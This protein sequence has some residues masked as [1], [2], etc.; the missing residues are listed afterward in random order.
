M[1]IQDQ[2]NRITN[3]VGTQSDLIEQI[4]SALQGKAVGDKQEQT[5][6]VTINENGTHHI[7]PDEGYTLSGVELNVDVQDDPNS[8]ELFYYE[9]Y[10][11]EGY[12]HTLVITQSIPS[13]TIENGRTI[14]KLFATHYYG[15]L[16]I[17]ARV[18]KV[19]LP[20]D[21]T[22][23]DN[24]LMIGYAIDRVDG[25]NNLVYIG[26]DSFY[27]CKILKT[28][29]EFPPNLTWLGNSAF[30]R[31]AVHKDLPP[32]PDGITNIGDRCF[33]YSYSGANIAAFKKLPK[34]LVTIGTNAFYNNGFGLFPETVYIPKSVRTIG[35]AAFTGAICNT[36]TI[37]FNGTPETIGTD[38]FNDLKKTTG[39]KDIYVPWTEGAVANAPWGATNAT[40]HYNTQYDADGNPIIEEV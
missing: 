37:I 24:T 29:S 31:C 14:P 39:I 16:G 15:C 21:V 20:D 40:I 26:N 17:N 13:T 10:D 33:V 4:K 8:K 36:K 5:K 27:D 22:V 2:I 32:L 25:W 12:P 19:V 3:E 9:D 35:G 1:A 23:L 28:I 34:N 7:E 30:D 6:E 38:A 11:E 18:N